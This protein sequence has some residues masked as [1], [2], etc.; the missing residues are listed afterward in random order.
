[1]RQILMDLVNSS[2]ARIRRLIPV[3]IRLPTLRAR[4]R[5]IP[6]GNTLLERFLGIS[7]EPYWK[8]P[9]ASPL[10]GHDNGLHTGNEFPFSEMICFLSMIDAEGTI[11]CDNVPDMHVHLLMNAAIYP[12]KE[13]IC[14]ETYL[15][16][17]YTSHE[18]S[19]I[20]RGPG[21]FLSAYGTYDEL[22]WAR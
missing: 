2:I 16:N 22:Q 6:G 9:A 11:V 10:Y 1:M 19:G 7:E 15:I 17:P 12:G 8:I 18:A 20:Y 4:E 21:H 3:H 14:H 13:E 5:T